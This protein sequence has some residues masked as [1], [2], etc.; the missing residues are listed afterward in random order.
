MAHHTLSLPLRIV[1]YVMLLLC[2]CVSLVWGEMLWQA[3]RDGDLPLWAPLLAP[4]TFVA[5]MVVFFAD[6]WIAVQREHYPAS[7]AM[8]QVGFAVLFFTLLL[9]P[10]ALEMPQERPVAETHA[11][12]LEPLLVL[13]HHPDEEVRLAA[14][15]LVHGRVSAAVRASV[16]EGAHND[17][18]EHVREACLAA[19]QRIGATGVSPALPTARPGMP[20]AQAP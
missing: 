15:E 3:F 5:F 10:H 16:T 11:Y 12:S 7:R 14:C 20:P 4:A 19:L 1:V 18:V 13:L 9:P 17:G 8:F 2:T 6:R